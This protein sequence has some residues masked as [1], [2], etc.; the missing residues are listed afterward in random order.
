MRPASTVLIMQLSNSRARKIF[1]ADHKYIYL[2]RH[3]CRK[4]QRKVQER[5]YNAYKYNACAPDK[6]EYKNT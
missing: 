2:F 1:I 4:Y 6:N 5:K 3:C